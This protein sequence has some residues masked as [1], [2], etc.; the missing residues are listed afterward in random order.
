MYCVHSLRTARSVLPVKPRLITV[1]SSGVREQRVLVA[2][3]GARLGCRDEARAE[4][5]AVGA[6]RDRGREAAP[7]EDAARGDDRHAVADLV[8][9]LRDERHRRDGAV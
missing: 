4:P 1:S 2:A 5:H 9:D 3:H 6:E 7:V 8:D